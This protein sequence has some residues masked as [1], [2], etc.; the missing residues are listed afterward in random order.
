MLTIHEY[1][2]DCFQFSKSYVGHGLSQKVAVSRLLGC[3][4]CPQHFDGVS[5]GLGINE[6]VVSCT[7]ENEIL[8]QISILVRQI[9]IGSRAA[10]AISPRCEQ[11]ALLLP[12]DRYRWLVVHISP[13]TPGSRIGRLNVPIK[14]LGLRGC[15]SCSLR[16][17][18]AVVAPAGCRLMIVEGFRH[19]PRSPHKKGCIGAIAE[20]EVIVACWFR[21]LFDRSSFV[22]TVRF[23]T[24]DRGVGALYRM[25]A[26]S[27]K[28]DGY[29]TPIRPAS[30]NAVPPSRS[31]ISAA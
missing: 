14:G 31:W 3:L 26:G 10:V 9:W 5:V 27:S 12:R 1:I 2:R 25:L 29:L 16:W 21:N 24:I 4:P 19:Q 13:C 23:T 28:R 20:P 17:T 22:L 8:V 18:S 30:T 7:K 6:S 11:S 15:N